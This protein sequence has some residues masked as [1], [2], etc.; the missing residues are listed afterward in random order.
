MQNT[1]SGNDITTTINHTGSAGS[2]EAGGVMN[3]YK[4]SV[5]TKCLRYTKYLGD[6][7]S[8]AFQDVVAAN[9]YPDNVIEKDECIGH[10]QKRVG[11]CLRSYK[12]NYKGKLLSD[13]K[14]LCGTGRLT[15]RQ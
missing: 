5:A 15:K 13:K 12:M 2:M 11:A 9:I 6:G 1:R 3:I 10:A 4:R 8:K 14:G 7:D